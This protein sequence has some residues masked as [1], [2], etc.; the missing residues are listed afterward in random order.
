[1][2]R[3]FYCIQLL[4]SLVYPSI[5][6]TRLLTLIHTVLIKLKGNINGVLWLID[7]NRHLV[8]FIDYYTNVN[9]TWYFMDIYLFIYFQTYSKYLSY[10]PSGHFRRRNI[11][12]FFNAFPTS[13]RRRY[14]DGFLFGVEKNVEKALKNWRRNF[15]VEI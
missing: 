9:S 3:H 4:V 2:F 11:L 8:K 12:T 13:N 1:M 10:L 6:N 14:F 5:I 7:I 15:D